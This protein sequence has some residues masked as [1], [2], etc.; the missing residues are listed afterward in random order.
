MAL[1]PGSPT[2]VSIVVCVNCFINLTREQFVTIIGTLIIGNKISQFIYLTL[3][4][5]TEIH[6][7]S[8]K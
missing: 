2:L 6:L 4:H 3:M 5:I 7:V 8:G 1:L